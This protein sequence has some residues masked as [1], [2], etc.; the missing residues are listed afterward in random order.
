LFAVVYLAATGYLFFRDDILAASIAR[1]T[2]M[3]DA[4]EDR[5]ASL[6]AD[7]D[8][9]TSRQLL[10]QQAFEA[11]LDR[12]LDRQTALDA[13]QDVIAGLSQAVR[14]AGLT[15]PA[16]AAPLPSPATAAAPSDAPDDEDDGGAAQ[17]S[18]TTGSLEAPP[19]AGAPLA[20]AMLRKSS[21]ATS[22]PPGSVDTRIDAVATSLDDLARE[23]VAYV[24]DI[25]GTVSDRTGRI[26]KVLARIGYPVA[27]PKGSADDAV[28]GPFIPLDEAADPA[29]FRSSVG[30]IA[31]QI[32]RYT[33]VRRLALQLPLAPPIASGVI[34]SGFGARM[35]PFLGRPAVHPGI[36]FRAPVGFPV[37]VTAAGTVI[38]AENNAGY[39][40]MV[41]VDH[42][43]GV[44]TRYAHLS[45]ILVTAGQ[46][47]AKGAIVGRAGSTGRSTG[48]HLHYEVR[49][50]GQAVDP[51]R[52]IKAGKEISPL[53]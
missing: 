48:P 28:G 52:F 11:K 2:R 49:L 30:L 29:T 38:A 4:Y 26:A 17:D 6:R 33:A 15:P 53:L 41:E 19:P 39:G 34:T 46:V 25:A 47:L 3:R 32:E 5:I 9:L 40:N 8:R 45:A 31:G 44:T 51:L 37:R 12:L 23:Q 21:G 10:D 18:L 14:R 13:R 42:G 20:L 35:D 50:D 7:I 43:N 16:S 24:D 22:L 36:D 1:Q 27:K